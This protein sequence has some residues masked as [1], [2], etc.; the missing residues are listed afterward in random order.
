MP[1][2]TRVAIMQSCRLVVHIGTKHVGRIDTDAPRRATLREL[3]PHRPE[4]SVRG[5]TSCGKSLCG[6][7]GETKKIGGDFAAVRLS[8]GRFFDRTTWQRSIRAKRRPGDNKI[9][10]S[11]AFTRSCGALD[12]G[13]CMRAG[14]PFSP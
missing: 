10:N 7:G 3:D 9:A 4:M 13:I 14:R 11:G 1:H 12:T 8:P 6:S 2:Q 5:A